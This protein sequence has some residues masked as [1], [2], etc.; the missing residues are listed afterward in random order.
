MGIPT[1]T[2]PPADLGDLLAEL[3]A[4]GATLATITRQ[5]QE[6]RAA[7]LRD[8]ERYDALVAKQ[9]EAEEARD[10]AAQIRQ[11]V[12]AFAASAFT[13]EA[14]ATAAGVLEVAR[15]SEAE[16]AA[17][18]E[19]RQREAE[20]LVAQL[21]L[22]R[23]LAERQRQAEAEAEKA[24]A[25]EAEKAG[26]LSGA[27][28][29]AREA[30]ENGRLEEAK[31]V[32]GVAANEF[33]GNAEIASL[34]LNIAQR[35]RI[36][37]VDEAEDALWDARRAWRRD[38]AAAVARLEALD[39]ASLPEPLARQVFGAWAQACARLC[40]ERGLAEPLRYAPDPGRGAVIAR[41]EPGAPYTVVSAL[42]M[43]GGWR[44]GSPVGE[45][46]ARRARP[47]R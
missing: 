47:L 11:E 25:A 6:T 46:Q 22:G 28:S 10:R 5:D 7:A 13:D 17:L 41:E 35:E 37:K 20:E 1:P 31:T 29:Q 30:L 14:C 15:R 42:G 40:R 32:L 33:P 8:L 43:G 26:R 12:E 38:P 44:P 4:A 23:L 27:L 2:E 45:G 34:L 18:A 3:E 19:Q 39:P 24:K 16:A 36:V 9:R 21:D